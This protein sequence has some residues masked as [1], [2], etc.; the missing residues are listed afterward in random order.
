MVGENCMV[1]IGLVGTRWCE[2]DGENSIS[3]AKQYVVMRNGESLAGENLWRQSG[4]IK[5]VLRI[6]LKYCPSTW[7]G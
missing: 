6:S 2:C 1:T 4:D 5:N 7:S 3:H